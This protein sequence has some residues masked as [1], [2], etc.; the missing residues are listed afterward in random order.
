MAVA[1]QSNAFQTDAFETTAG[2]QSYTL[3]CNAGTYSETGAS[4]SLNR[5]RSLVANTANYS[6][7]G[8]SATLE[9]GK[10]IIASVGA[11]SVSGTAV[12]IL[13]N[14]SL[15]AS[16]GSYSVSGNSA[17][18]TKAAGTLLSGQTGAYSLTGNAATLT[19][20]TVSFAAYSLTCNAGEYSFNGSEYVN[21][22]YVAD[23]YVVGSASITKYAPYPSP[24]DVRTGVV[25]GPNKEYTGTMTAG[26][27]QSTLKYWDGSQW[28]VK[29]LKT[30]NGTTW[31]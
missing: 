26:T 3:T 11:Y 7:T 19:K 9:V 13:V 1:F 24:N 15:T 22:G 27:P 30:W 25:Y 29:G 14:R 18:L 12:T 5:G 17:I 8:V 4:A 23:G 20:T 10:K 16:A 21:N 6:L 28:V 31:I 2:V